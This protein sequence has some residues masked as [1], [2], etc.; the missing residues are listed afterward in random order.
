MTLKNGLC[1]FASTSRFA[2]CLGP[3]F[4]TYTSAP[5]ACQIPTG[6]HRPSFRSFGSFNSSKSIC[7]EVSQ[8]VPSCLLSRTLPWVLTPRGQNWLPSDLEIDVEKW[9]WPRNPL[10]FTVEYIPTVL[11]PGS[12]FAQTGN[13]PTCL[14]NVGT[15]HAAW[16]GARQ[17]LSPSKSAST[18]KIVGRSRSARTMPRSMDGSSLL[19][20][21]IPSYAGHPKENC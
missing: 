3:S 6:R 17:D 7:G 14:E 13:T 1:S 11:R 8:H 21:A 19:E 18:P 10:N 2:S 5:T 9:N 16:P 15:L 20:S 4:W 12:N